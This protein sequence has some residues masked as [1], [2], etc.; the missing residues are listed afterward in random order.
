MEITPVYLHKIQSANQDI[1]SVISKF[2]YQETRCI[3]KKGA[4]ISVYEFQNILEYFLR[5][6][7]STHWAIGDLIIQ[8]EERG[9]QAAVNHV[10]DQ[11]GRRYSTLSNVRRVCLRVPPEKRLSKLPFTIYSE[12]F[13]RSTLEPSEQ[14]AI[15]SEAISSNLPTLKVR[16]LVQNRLNPKNISLDYRD[17]LPEGYGAPTGFELFPH[18]PTSEQ[19]VVLLFG[20]LAKQLGYIIEHVQTSCPDCIAKKLVN[21]NARRRRIYKTVRIEFELNSSSFCKHQH[22]HDSTDIIV[23]WEHDWKECPPQFHVVEL[24]SELRRIVSKAAQ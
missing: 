22:H 19:G 17:T 14:E 9:L 1:A 24:K 8:M 21:T 5:F 11:V 16:K 4:E 23:C 15:L 10:C 20:I 2:D 7:E 3:V 6:N 18:A 13:T 12:I